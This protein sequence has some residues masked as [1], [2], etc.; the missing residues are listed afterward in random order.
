MENVISIIN[1]E[2]THYDYLKWKR[3]NVTFR[4]IKNAGKDNNVYGSFGKG[5][6]TVPLTNKSMAKEYGKVYF[7][8][9]AKPKNP[10]VVYGINDAELLRQQLV[11]DFCKKQGHNKE[12]DLNF[13]ESN[14]TIEDEMLKRG[15][16]GLFIKGRE[17]VNYSPPDNV[18]YFESER[19]LENYYYSSMKFDDV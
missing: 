12:Y 18:M 9:N 7:V 14:T 16:D 2:L 6:Y 5:L 3:N 15:Y 17:M 1:E 4:G 11:F 10:K 13:F 8:L 19:Q